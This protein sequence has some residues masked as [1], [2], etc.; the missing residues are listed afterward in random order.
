[1]NIGLGFY[2][3]FARIIPGAF[4]FIALIQL[5][6][7]LNLT[8]FDLQAFNDLGIIPSLA[9]AVIAYILGSI[10]YP[11]SI[12]WHRLFKP[13]NVPSLAFKEFQNRN[14]GWKFEFHGSDWKTLFA[15]IRKESPNLATEIDKQYA[16]YIMLGSISFALI[17]LAINQVIF[18]ILNRVYINLIYAVLLIIASLLTAREGRFFQTRFYQWIFETILSYQLKPD[19][20]VKRETDKP[21]PTSKSGI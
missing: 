16:L 14:P 17:F 18:V 12:V 6:L 21:A 9:L 20:F 13:K 3:I 19:I 11:V 2:E 8:P 15:Y 4:Y 10:F 5:A 7:I 1:M